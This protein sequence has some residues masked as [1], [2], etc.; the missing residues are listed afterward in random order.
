MANLVSRTYPSLQMINNVE[1]EIL[2][3]PGFLVKSFLDFK[4]TSALLT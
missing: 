4:D 2:S 3:I 1:T